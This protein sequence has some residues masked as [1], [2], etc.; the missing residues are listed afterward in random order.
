M[1][2]LQLVRPAN[3]LTPSDTITTVLLTTTAQALD[4][5]A[6]AQFV[7]FSLS[8]GLAAV[9][10]GSTAAAW[11]TATSTVPSSSE[12]IG[13]PS[14]L[15]GITLRDLHSTAKTSGISLLAPVAGALMTLSWF[16]P[17]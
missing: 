15:Q 5:P 2:P 12:L 11:P 14:S 4:V 16:G 8:S 6:G 13:T 9:A 7:G 17:G 1:R 3:V 10:Y